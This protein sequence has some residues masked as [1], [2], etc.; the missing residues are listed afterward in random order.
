MKSICDP[1]I[2]RPIATILLSISISLLGIASYRHLPVS[3]LPKVDYPVIVVTAQFPGMSAEMMAN[4]IAS[5]LEKEFMKIDGLKEVLSESRLGSTTLTLNF[6]LERS[7]DAATVDVQA[8]IARSKYKLPSDMPFDPQYMK[9]NPNSDPIFY[10]GLA[11]ESMPSSELYDYA[12]IKIGQQLSK[13]DGV[14]QVQVFGIPRAVR[15][16]LDN[17]KLQLFHL[18]PDDVVKAVQSHSMI[19]SMGRLKGQTHT[20]TLTSN[21][22]LVRAKDYRSIVVKAECGRPVYLEDIARCED[23]SASEDTKVTL[24]VNQMKINTNSLV[25]LAVNQASGANT[26]EVSKRIHALLPHVEA[27]LP[28]TLKMIPIYDKASSIL[29]SINEVKE[30]IVIAFILVA[31]VIFLFLGRVRETIIPIVA[32]PLSLFITF[33]VMKG[34]GYSLDNLSL[35]ALTLAIGFLV[36]DAIVFLENVVRHMESG[37]SP[38]EASFKGA[39]EIS[40]TILSMTFSLMA[41]FLPIVFMDGQIGRIF[42]EFSITLIVA[43]LASGIVSLTLTPVMCS[44]F[45]RRHKRNDKSIIEQTANYLEQ[46]FIKIYRKQL[47]WVF[48]RRP[49][50]LGIW[51]VC[52]IGMIYLFVTLPKSFLP[53]GDSGAIMGVFM[54]QTGVSPTQM[55]RYQEQIKAVINKH[56]STKV[57]IITSGASEW[58]PDNQGMVVVVLKDLKHRKSIRGL[59]D[60]SIDT[61]CKE[62]QGMMLQVPGILPLIK[63]MPVL[64]IHTSSSS[65]NRGKYV[66]TL[67]G[68]DSERVQKAAQAMLKNLAAISGIDRA[69][70]NCN[71]DTN[72]PVM[73]I[74]YN[75]R[76]LFQYGLAPYTL[77][78]IIKN[79]LSL[80]Y[81]YLIKSDSEQYK[82]IVASQRD[83]RMSIENIANMQ[84][85]NQAGKMIPM[86]ALASFKKTSGMISVFHKNNFPSADIFFNLSGKMALSKTLQAIEKSAKGLAASGVEGELGGESKEFMESMR[87]LTFLLCVAVFVM[88]VVLGCLYEHW[89]HPLTVLSTLP[90]A[91]AGGLLTLLIFHQECSLYAFIGLFM[92]MGIIK[93]NGIILVDFAV[94]KQKQG[95]KPEK[96][97]LDACCERF[98]PILMTTVSTVLGILPIACGM[99]ADGA[100]RIPLGLSVAGGLIFAQVMTLYVTPVI[101]LFMDRFVKI[102]QVESSKA[103]ATE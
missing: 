16:H 95:E 47:L 57:A 63:P 1:F 72:N 55:H 71:F 66:Y 94:M 81:S 17:R 43:I 26:V 33:V 28:P 53:A 41:T 40:F 35:M 87:S 49:L 6:E 60:V 25:V 83:Q 39:S 74:D 27:S 65:N 4:S 52:I 77:E 7:I 75:R 18:S 12:N 14:S 50:F 34:L 91:L 84:V 29:D 100:S 56:P 13:I 101:Y 37:M 61:I 38:L 67:T 86:D 46:S 69:S 88:Y 76:R 89:I 15:V 70:I 9:K 5:P 20:L 2:K 59:K 103:L 68:M 96:A 11:S 10:I 82:V 85:K 30:T 79:S 8:A 58:L 36:D 23:A 97:I 31:I 99:G 45:L 22:Q 3:A 48:Q 80:N 54:A 102:E 21:G 44:R 90:V 93:K 78:A 98:R 19:L 42:R 32:I 24:W 62:L 64:N 73:N 92:L 51:G